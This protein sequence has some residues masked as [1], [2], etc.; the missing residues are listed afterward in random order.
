MT[1]LPSPRASAAIRVLAARQFSS[2]SIYNYRV[3]FFGQMVSLIGTWMQTTG[4]AWL[5]LR[6]TGS[7]LAL[8]TVA[9]LQFLPITLLS[10]FGGVFADRLPKRKILVA[11][12]AASMV[13]A[14]ALGA[15]V[16]TDSVQIWHVYLLA[17]ALG[18]C[19]A[20]DGPSRQSFVV[21]LVGRDQLVNAVAL[22]A[23][24]F[25]T[26]R[27]VGPAIAGVTIA[28]VGMEATFFMNG[29]S[30]IAVLAAYAAM[31]SGE[32]YPIDRRAAQGNV[33]SQMGEGIR[34]AVRTPPVLFV[35]ILL[36]F[37]GTF[38][39]NFVVIVPLV[40]EFVLHSGA[41]EFGA[42]MSFLGAGSLV[43]ALVLAGLGRTS[44]RIMLGG[45]GLFT[46][47]FALIAA[48][49][50]Y[51]LTAGLLFFWGMSALA[52]T[53][54]ANTTLQLTVPDELRGRVM[55]IFFLLMAGS[56]PIGGYLV[57]LLGERI[58]VQEA[59]GVH[60]A[61]CALGIG[62]A[63]LYR[64]LHAPAFEARHVVGAAAESPPVRP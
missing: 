26:A 48:S 13:Q 57:G 30:Y 35:L 37:I 56:T 14:F 50:W 47:L 20:I 17:L 12:Q 32:F 2:L 7:P 24:I 62:I 64:S 19:N 43:A 36:A 53:T 8:G 42:L 27:I 23:S 6:L 52:F 39:H 63:L 60:A 46:V 38:G 5:V 40:A 10:L 59:L 31:R 44:P 33:M 4:Q 49:H 41:T 58:G 3:Y 28:L 15:L 54:T 18:I 11:C 9:T 29:A 55:S 45:A 25:N 34:Y 21:E 61:L 51:W 16:L 22:N 1:H